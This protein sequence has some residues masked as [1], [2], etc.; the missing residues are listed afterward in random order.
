[1]QK[2]HR[3]MLVAGVAAIIAVACVFAYTASVRSEAS[4]ARAEALERYGGERVEVAVATRDI[5]VGTT[6]D[7]GS[8]AMRE[9][10]VDLL[11]Q[12]SPAT[13]LDQVVGQVAQV[14]IARNEPVLSTRVGQG[15]SRIAVPQG[16]EAV[17]VS[18]DDVLAVGGAIK[19]GS[20]VDVYVEAAQGKITRLG[21]KIL[22]LETSSAQEGSDEKITWVTLAVTPDSV[23]ELIYA[24]AKGT[25]HFA[26]PGAS[27]Q[28]GEE[29]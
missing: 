15:T 24:S 6:I 22:V 5:S 19:A 14:D 29:R 12:G 2:R 17:S 3:Q 7:A 23:S 20:L 18:S 4:M 27:A 16:L 28:G 21:E 25:I 13:S 8:V 26:L 10:L 1:M 11:P 9:W